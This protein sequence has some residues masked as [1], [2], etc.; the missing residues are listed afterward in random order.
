VPQGAD[1]YEFAEPVDILSQLSKGPVVVGDD[2]APFWDC[3][4][5][6]KWNMRRGALDRVR[7]LAAA[8]R[9]APGDYGEVAR[10]LKKVLAKDANVTCAAA[11]ADAAAALAGGLRREFAAAARQLCP[12]VLERFR[13]KNSIMSKAADE[14]LRAMAT[15]CYSLGEVVDEYVA[16]LA[17]KNPK[18]RLDTLRLLRDVLAGADKAQAARARDALLPA[19]AKLAPDADAGIREAA[20]GAL[21]AYALKMGSYG[22]IQ[23]VSGCRNPRRPTELG[24]ML[25][26]SLF[27]ARVDTH[28]SLMLLFCPRSTW[29]SWTTSGASS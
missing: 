17:H 28:H 22:A 2:S 24:P 21:V 23:P 20:A 26:P 29:P 5:S 15:H 27:R 9:L 16:A 19:V 4:A 12:A 18:V 14:A 25:A 1:A 6:K 11:A 7:A 10:E 3:F 8:P 13:E